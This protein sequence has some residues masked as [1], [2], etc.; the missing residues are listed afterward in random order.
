MML[1]T[2]R[3]LEGMERGRVYSQTVL[4]LSIGREEENTIQLNDDR[5]SRFHVKLQDQSGRVILTDLDSTNGTRVNGHPIQMRV[6]QQGDV[7]SVGRCVLLF[8]MQTNAV[9]ES[10]CSEEDSTRTVFIPGSPAKHPDQNSDVEH[11]FFDPTD[12]IPAAEQGELFPCMPPEIPFSMTGLERV[13]L[14]DLLSYVH[15][16]LGKI[17]GS[18]IE[19]LHSAGG[20]TV[21][22]DWTTWQKLTALQADVAQYRRCVNNPHN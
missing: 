15:V 22:C 6:M 4:P 18:T 3:V 19:D 20:R 14:S 10:S 1:V 21:R 9:S 8:N 2:I 13:Q 11:E 5:I 17:V 7:I 16:Q 12:P